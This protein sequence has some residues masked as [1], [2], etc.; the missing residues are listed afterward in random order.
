MIL[1]EGD[2]QRAHALLIDVLRSSR[3]N[4]RSDDAT[5]TVLGLACCATG[6]GE[7]RHAAVL[8]GGADALLAISAD[9]WE[10]LE[11]R[12]R[13]EDLLTLRAQLGDEFESLYA[14][15]RAMAH[16]EIVKLALSS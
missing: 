10:T 9:E 1:L 7:T 3:L 8:H 11:S 14:S 5:Y 12:I 6:L 16:D 13:E 4:S 2:A 15:G